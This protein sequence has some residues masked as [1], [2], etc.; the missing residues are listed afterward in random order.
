VAAL[1]ARARIADLL[2][3]ERRG[4]DPTETRAAIVETALAHHLVS[5]HTSLVAIDKTP[6]R[7][8]GDPLMH[9]QVPNLIP[10][11]QS[12]AALF[13][14]PATASDAPRLRFTGTIALLAALLLFAMSAR[15]R[16]LQHV[17]TR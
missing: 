11:G 14:F 8:G 12:G 9:E 15:H 1:W 16:K 13:G 6:A 10:H 17:P 2:D 5:K 3:N 4:A 7:P